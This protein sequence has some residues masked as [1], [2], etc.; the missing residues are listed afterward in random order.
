MFASDLWLN[1]ISREFI[2][3][4]AIR[5]SAVKEIFGDSV[6]MEIHRA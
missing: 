4:D 2:G 1:D 6:A 5:N 3:A